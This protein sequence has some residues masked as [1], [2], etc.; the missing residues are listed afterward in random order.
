MKHLLIILISTLLLSSFL[1]S[2]EK[3]KETL[4]IRDNHKGD[5]LY[6]WG[7][8]PEIAWK[9]FG[10]KKTHPVY[11]GDVKNGVPNGL[12]LTIFPNGHKYEGE[13][14]DGLK[15]G[16]GRL[17]YDDGEKYE[18]EHKSGEFHGQGTYTWTNGQKYEGEF[19]DGD[20]WNGR[21]YDNSGINKSKYVNGVNQ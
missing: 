7:E 12:G 9:G 3:N 18:G 19:K 5:T 20:K 2:C 4:V 11:K 6:R 16:Q 15:N 17:I 8:D 10:E 14:R 13:W 1:T 21:V